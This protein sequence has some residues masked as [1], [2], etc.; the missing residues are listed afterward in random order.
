MR[1]NKTD[2]KKLLP[3]IWEGLTHNIGIKLLSVVIALALWGY[4]LYANPS[5]TREKTLSG[6]SITVSGQSVLSSRLLA[7]STDLDSVRL[8]ARGDRPRFTVRLS[9]G[10]HRQCER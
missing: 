10:L 4:V 5:I 7:L 9:P 6:V 3:H 1:V 2:I 8:S